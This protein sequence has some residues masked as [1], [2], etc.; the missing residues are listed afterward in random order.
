MKKITLTVIFILTF[1]EIFAQLPLEKNYSETPY[2]QRVSENEGVYYTLNQN[3]GEINFYNDN[4]QKI[5]SNNIANGVTLL[6]P[7]KKTID[8]DNDIEF[9]IGI[10][11]GGIIEYSLRD[12]DGT[13]II[14]P[15][16]NM[17]IFQASDGAKLRADNNIY[18]LTGDYQALFNLENDETTGINYESI[19]NLLPPYPNPSGSSVNI[20]HNVGLLEIYNTNGQLIDSKQFNQSG[21]YMFNTKT[22]GNYIYKINGEQI[23]RFII[24]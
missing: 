23:G 13:M 3:T 15:N 8:N 16:T 21:I 24:Q 5:Q 10:N 1:I 4:H 2:Y 19:D 18:T 14:G 17:A 9:I 7:S 12:D 20:P 6:Y 22:S 11:V